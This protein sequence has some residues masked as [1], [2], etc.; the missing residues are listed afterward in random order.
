M[1][2]RDV[3]AIYVIWLR[4]L[5]RFWREKARIITALVQPMMWLFIM[6]VGLGSAFGRG[7][8]FNYLQFV[9]PGIVS[10][11]VL[12]AA[13]NSGLSLVWD[14]EFGFFK[15]ILISPVSRPAIV[16]GKI[17]AG[18]TTAII[19]GMVVLLLA[20]LV[21]VSLAPLV[22]AKSLAYMLVMAISLSSVGI[23]F[24][25]R[26]STFHS[27]PLVMN[28]VVMPMFLLSG[29]MFPLHGVPRWMEVLALWNPVSYG[30]DIMRV[31][32]TGHGLFSP[33][34]SLGILG[35]MT[36]VMGLGAMYFLGRDY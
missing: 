24:G 3:I 21:G 18:S 26:I 32:I 14:K 6:G 12:F 33:G 5:K 15:E 16:T 11:T 4:E 1:S 25:A 35:A 34:V 17:L 29:A 20:P 36:V 19:Q 23:L 10:M 31:A 7:G 2:G 30:V 22:L 27:Y 9:F 28:F 8:G 13:I